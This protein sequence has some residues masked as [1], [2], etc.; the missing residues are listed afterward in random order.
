[1]ALVTK[2]LVV[3]TLATM[4]S[5]Y[6]TAVPESPHLAMLRDAKA[7]GVAPPVTIAFVK[8]VHAALTGLHRGLL[9]FLIRPASLATWTAVLLVMHLFRR[10]IGLVLEELDMEVLAAF[11]V[12][13]HDGGPAKVV[14]FSG[15]PPLEATGGSGRRAARQPSG[16]LLGG[17]S[18]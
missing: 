15:M 5:L 2:L 11:F 10:S 12:S 14:D 4:L 6:V 3:V 17:N 16:A 7:R 13:V 9:L 18:S 1:M 8:Q